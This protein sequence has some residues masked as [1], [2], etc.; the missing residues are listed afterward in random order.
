LTT[1]TYEG[2]VY[3]RNEGL[4]FNKERLHN[5]QGVQPY[6]GVIA[7]RDGGL[8]DDPMGKQPRESETAKAEE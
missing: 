5:W 8:P 1:K 6:P 7:P 2:A 4:Y 3:E